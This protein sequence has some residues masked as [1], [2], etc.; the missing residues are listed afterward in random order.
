MKI[1]VMLLI[2]TLAL[3]WMLTSC[4]GDDNGQ[5]V[6]VEGCIEGDFDPYWGVLHAHTSYS[7]GELTPADAFEYGRDEGDLDI[8]VIT[9][10]LEQLYLPFPVPEKWA[11][12]REQAEDAY[13]PGYF[14]SDCGYEYGS[15]FILPWFWSTGHNNVF[16]S[17]DLFPIIQLDFHCFYQSLVECPACIG[18]FNH[19][20]SS[21]H[22]NW[23][24]FEYFPDV[25]EKMNLFEFNS[26]PAWE[27][28]FEAL[29]AGW[30]V[31]PMYNQDN[32]DPDW[33]TRD[34]T[35]SGFYLADLTREDLHDAMLDRRSFMST[36][37]NASI[38]VT[39]LKK[40]W[41]GSILSGD[42]PQSI[43]IEVEAFDLDAGDGLTTIEIY[44]PAG[45]LLD[46][47]DCGGSKTCTADF[48]F[49]T[50]AE[51]Y[52]VAAAFEDDGDW[53]AAAP[54]W[55]EPAEPVEDF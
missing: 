10:H 55:V 2:L 19:P 34:G 26:D 38:K 23:N 15:G 20:G 5:D 16:F 53:L 28:F 7:D 9:D 44:G 22:E 46:V 17:D 24:L 33:G 52:F 11:R 32:H 30:H 12:C 37:K 51:T 42:V 31:S 27:L 6:L 3:G 21:E 50:P 1:R 29:D 43:S 48:I 54:I 41:M 8:L 35:R 40:C 45:E 39:A 25:D 18:Q 13:D 47:A 36:D 49:D 4:N 14:L